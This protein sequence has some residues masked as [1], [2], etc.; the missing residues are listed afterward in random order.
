MPLIDTLAQLNAWSIASILVRA[1]IYGA[2]LIAVGSLI[3][4]MV[5]GQ[6]SG[7]SEA[8][9][10]TLCA[11]TAVVAATMLLVA[12]GLRTIFLGGG[13]W[14][15]TLEPSL[16]G[17][18]VQGAYGQRLVLITLGLAV[19]AAAML[20]ARHWGQRA[21]V[22]GALGALLVGIGF[23]QA[24]HTSGVAPWLLAPLLM[25]HW[26]AASFWLGALYPLHALAARPGDAEAMHV[27]T[28]FGSIAAGAVASLLVAGIVIAYWLIAAVQPLIGSAY[29]QALL[30]KTTIVAVLLAL[31]A[32]NKLLAVPA[33]ANGSPTAA[34]HLQWGIR[35]EAVTATFILL[36]TALLTSAP[37]PPT[38]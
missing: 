8:K 20:T 2:A 9:L 21:V 11:A 25:V 35:L 28:R 22:P 4:R 36:I 18:A 10:S 14:R 7:V 30:V 29:G 17:L 16:W 23:G 26:L 6:P 15:A 31:A 12:W 19:V 38:L 34:H 3:F 32:F 27:L 24:G 33:F 5:F 1:V 13:M 37:S